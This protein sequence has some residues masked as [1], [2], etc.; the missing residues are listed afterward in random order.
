M[1]SNPN[2]MLLVNIHVG[3]NN[4]DNNNTDGGE[5]LICDDQFTTMAPIPCHTLSNVNRKI[6][7]SHSGAK[8][9][10]NR[11]LKRLL[12]LLLVPSFPATLP[13]MDSR[14]LPSRY[15][16][17]EPETDD[18]R[19]DRVVR[20]CTKALSIRKRDDLAAK[21]RTA[22]HAAKQPDAVAVTGLVVHVRLRL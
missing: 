6:I 20:F 9:M 8:S 13:N 17:S 11:S 12:L 16:C 21:G 5:M 15:S 10:P 4:D 22:E 1:C 18:T 7:S 3:T 19:T 14:D 2:I